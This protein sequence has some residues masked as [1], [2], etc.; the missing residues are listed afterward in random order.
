MSY[1]VIEGFPPVLH[2][3]YVMWVFFIKCLLYING[4]FQMC[5]YYLY[6]KYIVN[7]C[8]NKCLLL[9]IF[10]INNS[11]DVELVNTSYTVCSFYL[12]QVWSFI[13]QRSEFS[14]ALEKIKYLQ[15]RHVNIEFF[16]W[17]EHFVICLEKARIWE[18]EKIKNI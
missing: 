7:F 10:L 3:L 14:C 8:E 5:Y 12:F 13:L 18:N 4:W 15:S 6:F 16:L 1:V 17:L 9:N 2:V 11:L